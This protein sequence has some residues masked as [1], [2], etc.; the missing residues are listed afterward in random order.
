MTGRR[1]EQELHGSKNE[2]VGVI[3][4][5]LSIGA[6]CAPTETGCTVPVTGYRMPFDLLLETISIHVFHS[7]HPTIYS[8]Y[9]LRHYSETSACEEIKSYS[10]QYLEER[11]Q[12][13]NRFALGRLCSAKAFAFTTSLA[14]LLQPIERFLQFTSACFLITFHCGLPEVAR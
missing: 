11:I 13:A 5:L 2:I 8:N 14:D 6:A 10:M 4:T 12:T 9:Q 7:L 3:D 1:K